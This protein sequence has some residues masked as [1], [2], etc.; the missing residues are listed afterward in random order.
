MVKWN[1]YW[2]CRRVVWHHIDPDWSPL[3]SVI[4]GEY[5]SWHMNSVWLARIQEVNSKWLSL[6]IFVGCGRDALSPLGL[7][8]RALLPPSWGRSQLDWG[9]LFYPL[10]MASTEGAQSQSCSLTL[11]SHRS[12]SMQGLFFNFFLI[13]TSRSN[14]PLNLYASS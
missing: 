1:K 12:K 2:L 5:R 13:V 4:G 9:S 6:I 14:S 7:S 10:Q 3:Q 8:L 11:E